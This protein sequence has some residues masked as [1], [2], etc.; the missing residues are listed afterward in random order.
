MPARENENH[1]ACFK[2]GEANNFGAYP[3]RSP[4]CTHHSV[5]T[6]HIQPRT[7]SAA[8]MSAAGRDNP[9]S[10]KRPLVPADAS[11]AACSGGGGLGGSGS[12][13]AKRR[14]FAAG[15]G[16]RSTVAAAAAAAAE[17]RLCS[18]KI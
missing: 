6:I 12:P 8:A 13:N 9:V 3:S 1:T 2:A 10:R 14:L 18:A 17:V 7:K 4:N 15:P 16:S 11:P 5:Q